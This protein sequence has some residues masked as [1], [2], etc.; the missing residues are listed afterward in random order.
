MKTALIPGSFDP[1]TV[2]HLDIIERTCAIFDKVIVAVMINESKE[3]TFTIEERKKIAELSL[4]HLSNVTVV[5]STGWLYRLFDELGADVIVKGVRNS[6]DLEYENEMARF[7]LAKNPK[8][9][10]LYFPA[11][12]MLADVSSTAFRKSLDCE[13]IKKYI[14]PKAQSY[15]S[16]LVAK[17]I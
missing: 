4:S 1:M 13:G 9:H 8:A 6:V 17:K 15:V 5:S 11:S 16:E 7:N 10:T 12:D 2:G 3:Y 14:C